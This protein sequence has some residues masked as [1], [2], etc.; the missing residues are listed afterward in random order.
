MAPD[1]ET[2]PTAD[3]D[4]WTG[5]EGE[6]DGR[7]SLVRYRPNLKNFVGHPALSRRL[8]VV[9]DYGDDDASGMP[10]DEDTEAMFGFEGRLVDALDRDRA[11]VLA[12]VL[13]HAGRRTWQF[14]FGD[15]AVVQERIT[16]ALAN[17]PG[18]PIE[19]EQTPDPGWAE[20]TDLIAAVGGAE[21]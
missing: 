20:L 11:A 10:S 6:I 15:V 13:T 5:A 1:L 9:W 21:S 12:I 16:E 18:L 17:F 3:D 4:A 14:Y 7:P 2:I 19:M 8:T